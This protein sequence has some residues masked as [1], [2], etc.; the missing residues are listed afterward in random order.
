M[1]WL[2]G[3]F[4]LIAFYRMS[5]VFPLVFLLFLG[6]LWRRS[7]ISARLKKIYLW[8]MTFAITLGYFMTRV[9]LSLLFYLMFTG[10]GLVARIFKADMLDE[11]YDTQAASF[12]QRRHPSK[13]SN[14]ALNNSFRSD[15][16]DQSS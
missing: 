6:F 8:W 3:A 1:G 14:A 15:S 7:H 13:M 2:F 4:T 10:I 11:R 16:R 9:I 12:W 5:A